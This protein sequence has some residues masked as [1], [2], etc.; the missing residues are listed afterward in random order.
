ML[1]PTGQPGQSSISFLKYNLISHAEEEGIA[2][3]TS[4]GTAMLAG[5]VGG[6]AAKGEALC[7]GEAGRNEI[8]FLM[9]MFTALKRAYFSLADAAGKCGGEKGLLPL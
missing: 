3:L 5:A 8:P 9:D 7:G 2:R 1:Q 6:K 4:L